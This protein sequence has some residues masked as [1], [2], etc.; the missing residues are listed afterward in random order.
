MLC[1]IEEFK[2][3]LTKAIALFDDK[4]IISKNLLPNEIEPLT[5]NVK[6]F[7]TT[8]KLKIDL[9]NITTY[10]ELI[11]FLENIELSDRELI[12]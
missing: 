11:L 8:L 2:D 9:N 7:L 4:I 6:L 12:P 1:T 5:R 10:A 3:A